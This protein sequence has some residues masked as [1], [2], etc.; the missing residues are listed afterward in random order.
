MVGDELREVMRDGRPSIIGND[1]EDVINITHK[2]V[3][4][5]G[6]VRM[7]EVEIVMHRGVEVVLGKCAVCDGKGRGARRP[8]GHT[9]DL[10]HKNAKRHE[11]TSGDVGA[12]DITHIV[13]GESD[14]LGQQAVGFAKLDR[15]TR[16]QLYAQEAAAAAACLAT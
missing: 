15:P 5:V 1:A 10:L 11:I 3:E 7:V 14:K 6:M 9:K 16:V 2:A 8:H 12:A 4:A 13:E